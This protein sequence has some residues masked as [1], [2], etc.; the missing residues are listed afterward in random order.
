MPESTPAP[1]KACTKCGER[2][3]LTEFYRR[4]KSYRSWCKPCKNTAGRQWREDNPE[5]D[6]GYYLKNREKKI[7]AACEYQ[8]LNPVD[9]EYGRQRKRRWK[10]ANAD[11]LAVQDRAWKDANLDRVRASGTRCQNRRRARL[12]GLPSEPYT[13]ADLLARD[14]T[15]CVLC[16]AELDLSA[17][18]YQ[19]ASVTIEHL[20]CI[21]WPGSAGD[22]LSNVALAHH[23]CNMR[24]GVRP[25]PAAARK[26]RELLE[27][28]EFAT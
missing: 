11:R 9:P 24:R 19:P 5:Y 15:Q 27:A 20:E 2:K 28:A 22:V 26:R 21:S 18:R 14:G 17:E 6:F 8:R 25:H 3:P 7:T 23:S 13:V 1:A 10:A 16:G 4:G 12:R